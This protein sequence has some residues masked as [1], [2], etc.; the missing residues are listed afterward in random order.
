MNILLYFVNTMKGFHI[1]I[2][3]DELREKFALLLFEILIGIVVILFIAF[4][5][6]IIS[7]IVNFMQN[8]Y[9]DWEHFGTIGKKSHDVMSINEYIHCH[10]YMI[11]GFVIIY[12]IYF[13]LK[14]FWYII[15][16]NKFFNQFN[17]LENVLTRK[18]I[19][20]LLDAI[21]KGTI[22]KDILIN[23]FL[24]PLI[25]LKIQCIKEMNLLQKY[26]LFYT[27]NIEGLNIGIL[28]CL[29]CFSY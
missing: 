17:V 13:L 1:N 18:D 14:N 8:G 11:K 27:N 19:M 26:S 2:S 22:H 21:E 12:P 25:N 15:K 16:Y 24:L 5:H 7:L 9:I 6:T 3:S 28:S 20:K 23:K 4:I 29:S 10:W